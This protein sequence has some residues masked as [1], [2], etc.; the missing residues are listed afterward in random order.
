MGREGI[1]PASILASHFTSGVVD[2]TRPLCPYPAYEVYKGSG[3]TDSAANFVCHEPFQVPNYFVLN[4]PEMDPIAIPP[5]PSLA[6]GRHAA[7]T[8]PRLPT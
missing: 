3:S 1:A 2:R 4:G 6:I 5:R 8:T 7:T